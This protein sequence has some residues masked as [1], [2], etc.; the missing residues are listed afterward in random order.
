[1]NLCGKGEGEGERAA[2]L[3]LVG[4]QERI[5]GGQEHDRN[6]QQWGVGGGGTS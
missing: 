4:R 5:S 6:M 1:M 3:G 2:G